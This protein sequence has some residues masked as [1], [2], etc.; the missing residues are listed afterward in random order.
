[1]GLRRLSANRSLIRALACCELRGIAKVC[2]VSCARE[3]SSFICA[4][5]GALLV[6][7]VHR[8]SPAARRAARFRS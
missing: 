6:A 2:P 3:R 1:L 7:G 8:R 5:D 4:G